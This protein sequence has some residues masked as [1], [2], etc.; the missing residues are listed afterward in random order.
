M[1]IPLFYN[2]AMDVIIDE[3][4]Q[5]MEEKKEKRYEFIESI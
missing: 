3:I 4:N 1:E 5:V 2:G